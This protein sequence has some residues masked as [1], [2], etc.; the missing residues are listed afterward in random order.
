MLLESLSFSILERSR[1]HASQMGFYAPSVGCQLFGCQTAPVMSVDRAT[2]PG[3]I[4]LIASSNFVTLIG[5]IAPASTAFA[6]AED[7]QMLPLKSAQRLIAQMLND[8]VDIHCSVA[9]I[10]TPNIS[11]KKETLQTFASIKK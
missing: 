1:F 4:L 7:V 2:L 10:H 9:C 5:R 6:G 3:L 11:L 8:T